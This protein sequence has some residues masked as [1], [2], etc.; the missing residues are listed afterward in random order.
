MSKSNSGQALTSIAP[1]SRS[2]LL[3]ASIAVC[4][5]T[6]LT[7]TP[8]VALNGADASDAPLSFV[9]KINVGDQTACTGALVD[10]QWVLTAATC[11][12]SD[13]KPAAGEPAVTTTVT[14]GRTD[15]TQTG[16][17]VQQ[18]VEIVPRTDRD[19]VMVKL[20]KKVI[21]ADITPVRVATTPA[22]DNEQLTVAGFGRTKTQWVPNKLHTGTFTVASSTAKA[23]SLNGS[24]S[25]TACQGDAGGPALRT[26]D[27]TPE[28]VAVTS[29]SWQGGCLGTDPA[30]TR[31]G[32]LD[33]RVDDVAAWVA[34]TAFRVQDDYTGDGIGD[35]A[36]IWGDGSAHIYPGDKDKGLAGTNTQLIGTTTWKSVLQLAKG[37]F[38]NDGDADLVTVWADGTMHINQGNG[39]GTIKEQKPVTMGGNTW[40]TLKQLTAGDFNGDGNADILTVWYDGTMH[41]YPGLGNG[42]LGTGTTITYG[43][44]TWS[45]L[46]QLVAGD[47]DH[48]G[49]A[50]ALAVWNDGT[51][52]FYKGLGNGQLAAG[53][54]V[55]TGGDTWD[56]VKLMAGTDVDGDGVADVLAIWSDGTMHKYKGQG[57]G[58][59]AAGTAVTYGGTGWKTFL[60]LT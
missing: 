14:V 24:D 42:Q 6:G 8:A 4:C 32:A 59:L 49:V 30:E 44:D 17:S 18:A 55:T 39:D 13:G 12:A 20:A 1:L 46:S 33:T 53:K 48:D 35:L 27:G 54:T 9:A 21:D 43:G 38:T 25:A 40:K 23:V 16:G 5:T 51:L 45:T 56:S 10:P 57:N 22:A 50:D 36:S 2:L 28:L 3:A 41:L 26:V 29:T 47:F 7:A 31:T 37:D 11:F 19:L 58:Q 15:L 60:Q 34:Q 52:H